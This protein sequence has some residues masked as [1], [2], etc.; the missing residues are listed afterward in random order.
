MPPVR[1]FCF[2]VMPFGRKPTAAEPGKGPAEIDFN[3]LWDKAFFPL[4]SELG[5]QA[6]RADQETNALIVNQML[7]RLYFSDLVLA[8]L[9]TPNG[10]VYYEVGI[11]HAACK[12][13]CVLVAAD[14]SKPLFDLAQVRTV[15]Y[16][17][18]S[19]EIDD[20]TA[21]EVQEALRPAIAAMRAGLSP[22]FEVLPGYP[23]AVDRARL[24]GV[25]DQ[26]D[27]LAAFQAQLRTLRALPLEMRRTEVRTLVTTYP[28]GSAIHA[29]AVGLVHALVDVAD[30]ESWGDVLA[31]IDALDPSIAKDPYVREQRALALGKVGR[32][33]EAIA[34]LLALIEVAGDSSERQGLLGGRFRELIRA[35]EKAGRAAGEISQLRARAI[36]HYE[37]GMMLD[38]N[39][40]YP[41]SNLP[42]LYRA[43]GGVGDESRAQTALQVTSAACERAVARR[44]TDEWVRSTLLG[45]AFDLGDPR[46][47]EEAAERVRAEGAAGWKLATALAGLEESLAH[48]T[49]AVTHARLRAVLE[50]LRAAFRDA[51]RYQ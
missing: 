40:F 41:T 42:R 44:S 51:T 43:R 37:R 7:E 3:A 2:M 36:E 12:A 22:M 31:Y 18:R 4:L 38:L 24:A 1:P 23:A 8:D 48:I 6:V 35:A 49:D 29:V 11:R 19:G 16:P 21:R 20:D 9:T 27:V 15:R 28:P 45:V 17:L 39:D 46:K 50:D 33:N 47:A 34:E 32:T 13:G 25:Q 26:L 30:M 10:N 5:Y 14:W